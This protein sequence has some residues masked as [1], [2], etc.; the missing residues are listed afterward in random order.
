MEAYRFI[1]EQP[2]TESLPV[3]SQSQASLICRDRGFQA[4]Y[5]ESIKH[6]NHL[7]NVSHYDSIIF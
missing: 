3:W 5:S 7:A 2:K 6:L 1:A 4:P